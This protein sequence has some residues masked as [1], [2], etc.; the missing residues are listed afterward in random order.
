MPGA[1]HGKRA[2]YAR[3]HLLGRV[4]RPWKPAEQIVAQAD[5]NKIIDVGQFGGNEPHVLTFQAD[6]LNVHRASCVLI[7]SMASKPCTTQTFA[8]STGSLTASPVRS[9]VTG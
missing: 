2:H 7:L 1:A 6:R 5:A 4:D 8:C 3:S 9:T